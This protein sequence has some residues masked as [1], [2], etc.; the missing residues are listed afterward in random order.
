MTTLKHRHNNHALHNDVE[1]IKAAILSATKGAK[2]KATDM[3]Y[4]SMDSMKERSTAVKSNVANYT[5]KNPFQSLGVAL[6][7]GI[8]I[9]IYLCRRR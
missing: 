3:L 5:A 2:G 1:K 7:S 4:D 9:G 8:A 6:I